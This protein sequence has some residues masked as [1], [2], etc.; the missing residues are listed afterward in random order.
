MDKELSDTDSKFD[1]DTDLEPVVI[2]GSQFTN[3]FNADYQYS[4]LYDLWNQN[5]ITIGK[6]GDQTYYTCVALGASMVCDDNMKRLVEELEKWS[7]QI[8]VIA[9]SEFNKKDILSDLIRSSQY[10]I[11]LL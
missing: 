7:N 10:E 4:S 1:M 5:Y 2:Y 8:G 11:E 6:E 9:E 3:D